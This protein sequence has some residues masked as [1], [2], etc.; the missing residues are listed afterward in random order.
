VKRDEFSRGVKGEAWARCGGRCEACGAIIKPGQQ[1][2]HH[3]KPAG[4]GGRGVAE[5]CVVLCK[6][7]HRTITNERDIPAIA[8]SNRIR[9]R[10]AGI[11]RKSRFACSKDKPFKKKIGGEVVRRTR[12]S[13]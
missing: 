4:F 6:P 5:N 10:N 11:K 12:S 3:D 8:K 9:A 13:D 2:H 1:E 7:C